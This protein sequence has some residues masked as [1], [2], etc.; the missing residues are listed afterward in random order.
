MIKKKSGW[1]HYLNMPDINIWPIIERVQV[2]VIEKS[3]KAK[4][5]RD[6]YICRKILSDDKKEI[7]IEI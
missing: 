6:P 2:H 3:D 4:T 5:G 1:N 7:V